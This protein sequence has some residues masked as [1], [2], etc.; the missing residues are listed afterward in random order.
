MNLSPVQRRTL[1]FMRDRPLCSAV[2]RRGPESAYGAARFFDAVMLEDG[3]KH[4]LVPIAD[5]QKLRPTFRASTKKGV[6]FELT[7][8]GF[9]ALARGE[10]DG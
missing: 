1:R 10:I 8:R 4:V 7:A 2:C 5:W 6:L 9:T 3:D